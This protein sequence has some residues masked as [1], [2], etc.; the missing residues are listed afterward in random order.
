MVYMHSIVL[1]L[2]VLQSNKMEK[3]NNKLLGVEQWIVLI[4]IQTWLPLIMRT[5]SNFILKLKE[6][7]NLLK[8]HYNLKNTGQKVEM[9][10]ELL[11]G[12]SGSQM[13]KVMHALI[14]KLNFQF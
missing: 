11:Q 14:V 6:I 7:N 13:N 12:V 10:I 9:I 1:G 4:T 3:I 5:D 8:D 2:G